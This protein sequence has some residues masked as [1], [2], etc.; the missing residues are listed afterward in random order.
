MRS[1]VSNA[2]IN[3]SD[4][5]RSHKAREK[6]YFYLANKSVEARTHESSR[7]I[8]A[9]VTSLDL[10]SYKRNRTSAPLVLRFTRTSR[11][12]R[13]LYSPDSNRHKHVNPK[14]NANQPKC[15]MLA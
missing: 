12:G 15:Q 7:K 5:F 6:T 2:E 4:N 8:R 3:L 13:A 11:L 1:S 14:L 10:I 9:K